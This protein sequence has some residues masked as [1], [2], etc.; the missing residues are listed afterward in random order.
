MHLF[1]DIS[2]LLSHPS[3]SFPQYRAALLSITAAGVGLTL[4]AASSVV[5]AELFWNPGQIQ[6][7]TERERERERHTHTHSLSLCIYIYIF[8]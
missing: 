1:S 7:V 5:F 4:H 8:K 3:F 6:Q 2:S